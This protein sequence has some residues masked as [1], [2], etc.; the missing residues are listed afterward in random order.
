[1][2]TEVQNTVKVYSGPQSVDQVSQ[3]SQFQVSRLICTNRNLTPD[4]HRPR[5][6]LPDA[7]IRR[8]LNIYSNIEQT[9]HCDF[10]GPHRKAERPD[11][12]HL[13]NLLLGH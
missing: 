13:K 5:A 10:E 8:R 7:K 1:M 4:D 9:A 6:Y 2:I 3:A 11:D 12:S